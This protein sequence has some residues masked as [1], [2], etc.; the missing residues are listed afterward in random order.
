[1]GV[2]WIDNRSPHATCR[3]IDQIVGNLISIAE[4]VLADPS[5]AVTLPVPVSRW[6]S[7]LTVCGR[8][9]GVAICGR[10]IGCGT[11]C[12][13]CVMTGGCHSVRRIGRIVIGRRIVMFVIL[14]L[15]FFCRRP[16]RRMVQSTNFGGLTAGR[17]ALSPDCIGAKSLAA[18]AECRRQQSQ[19]QHL[20]VGSLH[21]IV[22]RIVVR[23]VVD[24]CWSV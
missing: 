5:I 24:H 12:R 8:T 6:A 16:D 7:L 18:A 11:A 3:R 10:A 20:M 1:M 13:E 19:Q 22:P 15:E 21:D 9:I 17:R 14:I 4:F 2:V 23:S